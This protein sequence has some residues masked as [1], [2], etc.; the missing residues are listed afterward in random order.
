MTLTIIIDLPADTYLMD[1]IWLEEHSKGQ[2]E[3]D[4]HTSPIEIQNHLPLKNQQHNPFKALKNKLNSLINAEAPP[5]LAITHEYFNE[6]FS[7]NIEQAE[8]TITC[9]MPLQNVSR[10]TP[11]K[12]DVTIS[13]RSSV[14]WMTSLKHPINLS[15]HWLND[16]GESV[17]FEGERTPLPEMCLFY[18]KSMNAQILIIPPIHPGS[19]HLVLS[20]VQEGVAWLEQKGF[21]PLTLPVNI[22]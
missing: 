1:V 21:T 18:H 8:G 13:N 17:I 11:F 12:L 16:R 5:Q 19:Y 14:N 3:L 6:V 10:N 4:R 9:T 15:Y 7:Q 22:T 2:R 20:A